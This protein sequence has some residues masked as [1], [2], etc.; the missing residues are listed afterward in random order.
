MSIITLQT[1]VICFFNFCFV[2]KPQKSE[3]GPP[4]VPGGAYIRAPRGRPGEQEKQLLGGPHGLTRA[5]KRGAAGT[6]GVRSISEM[7]RGAEPNGGRRPC[8]L[9]STADCVLLGT[10]PLS[11]CPFGTQTHHLLLPCSSSFFW[12]GGW[13]LVLGN[14]AGALD[15][16]S[17]PLLSVQKRLIPHAFVLLRRPAPS[18]TCCTWVVIWERS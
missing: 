12:G 11:N 3:N 14:V 2:H 17:K 6:A 1:S 18:C 7:G 15:A 13:R 10:P 4:S 16:V 8:P 5:N 9:S